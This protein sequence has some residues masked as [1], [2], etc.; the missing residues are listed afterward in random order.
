MARKSMQGGSLG[1]KGTDFTLA[2]LAESTIFPN[3]I[4]ELLEGLRHLHDLGLD[5]RTETA[6]SASTM[7]KTSSSSADE[8]S[9]KIKKHPPS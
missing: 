9:G 7:P 6:V 8:V 5:R 1:S 2:L 4:R 3:E